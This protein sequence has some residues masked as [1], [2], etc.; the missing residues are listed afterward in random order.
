MLLSL[1]LCVAL[2]ASFASSA[3]L[4]SATA[5]ASVLHDVYHDGD[6]ESQW[7]EMSLDPECYPF[8]T[9]KLHTHISW[10]DHVVYHLA[11]DAR[12]GYHVSLRFNHHYSLKGQIWLYDSES[13]KWV[14]GGRS[15]LSI[16][17]RESI[18]AHVAEEELKQGLWYWTERKAVSASSF[19]PCTK[20]WEVRE[21]TFEVRYLLKFSK[22]EIQ[23]LKVLKSPVRLTGVVYDRGVDTDGDGTY[24]YLEI[25][26]GVKVDVPGFYYIVIS[27]L[28]DGDY[29]YIRITGTQWLYLDAG[30]HVVDLTLYGPRI[31]GSGIDPS[32]IGGITANYYDPVW[33]GSAFDSLTDIPLSRTYLHTEFDAPGAPT[34]SIISDR[35]I[36]TDNNGFYNYLEIGVEVRV[37]VDGVY[38]VMLD[39]LT[40]DAGNLIWTVSIA[41]DYLREGTNVLYLVI[42]GQTIYYSGI[43]PS[44]VA[45]LTLTDPDG[46]EI[47]L[48]DV[49]L[50][51]TYLH[52]EFEAPPPPPP[53]TA[54]LTGFTT[55]RGV[56]TDGNGLYNYLEIGVEVRVDEAGYYNVILYWL[57]DEVGNWI[58]VWGSDSAYLDVGTQFIY[59]RLDGSTIR[60]EGL[61]PAYIW[62]ISLYDENWNPQGS[63]EHIPLSQTYL[64]TDFEEPP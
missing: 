55:D 15:S 43:D 42:D 33:G 57:L 11:S 52:T 58:W 44:R 6:S 8:T 62:W 59:L 50:S 18:K 31:R 38:R 2:V 53:P 45:S 29:N 13:E 46:E 39:G 36:D 22:G 10:T 26:V 51:R 40:D 28:R 17:S 5:K 1:G 41:G 47:S 37:D 19:N 54:A 25:G 61:N 32:H 64:Y 27:D 3:F 4:T 30:S 21:H 56:D 14:D 49:P 63:L 34:I 12:G 7:V 16:S 48:R 35:G 20:E 9:A 24:D 23:F 60:A